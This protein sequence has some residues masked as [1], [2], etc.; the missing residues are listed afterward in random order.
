MQ[1]GHHVTQRR[2][3][4]QPQCRPEL[5]LSGE[6]Q[7]TTDHRVA[8]LDGGRSLFLI[9]RRSGTLCAKPITVALRSRLRLG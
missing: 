3:A 7:P 5:R 9:M 2:R 4:V 1:T 6:V 8:A